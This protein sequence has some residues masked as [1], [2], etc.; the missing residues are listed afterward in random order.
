MM[1][2]PAHKHKYELRGCECNINGAICDTYI[3]QQLL[4]PRRCHF[5]RKNFA[6]AGSWDVWK[7]F[8]MRLSVTK[9]WQHLPY[10][11]VLQ[12]TQCPFGTLSVR[13]VGVREGALWHQEQEY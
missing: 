3:W 9:C 12:A 7:C 5:P 8:R 4:S 10:S 1:Q 6:G 2:T 11:E 13:T